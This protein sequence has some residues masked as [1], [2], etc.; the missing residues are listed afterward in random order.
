MSDSTKMAVLF[1]SILSVV[2]FFM[3]KPSNTLNDEVYHVDGLS[4]VEYGFDN[5]IA[6]SVNKSDECLT[7]DICVFDWISTEQVGHTYVKK[8]IRVENGCYWFEGNPSGMHTYDSR[9]F[10][11]VTDQQ[12]HIIG[13]VN[14]IRCNSGL[15]SCFK[16]WFPKS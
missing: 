10:G 15:L 1:L 16:G 9:N 12:I 5:N 14:P 13:T 4:M 11:C 2:F 8:L 7:G 3:G 6:I